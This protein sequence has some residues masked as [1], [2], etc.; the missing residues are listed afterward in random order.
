MVHPSLLQAVIDS[1][2]ELAALL[3]NDPTGSGEA[4]AS[5][6]CSGSSVFFGSVHN[7]KGRVFLNAL[8]CE[9]VQRILLDALR[10]VK[11][12]S[13]V[14]S[15]SEELERMTA[16]VAITRTTGSMWVSAEVIELVKAFHIKGGA[17]AMPS[18]TAFFKTF[19]S[20]HSWYKHIAI[21]VEFGI[22]V[23]TDLKTG[24]PNWQTT[25]LSRLL[26]PNRSFREDFIADECMCTAARKYAWMV[27]GL[28]YDDGDYGFCHTVATGGDAW[29]EWLQSMYPEDV[30]LI[31]SCSTR[32]DKPD[33]RGEHWS[34]FEMDV[35]RAEQNVIKERIKALRAKEYQRL[36]SEFKT[37]ALKVWEVHLT[38]LASTV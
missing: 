32:T 20:A 13:K 10:S 29:F 30:E 33:W 38:M 18:R 14:T 23:M 2:V 31:K 1:T 28:V 21:P 35:P 8:L 34:F 22:T 7:A 26:D 27:N 11:D 5:P 12:S 3:H 6:A 25:Y 4:A 36:L 15:P 9:D 24:L 37:K 19:A 16:F 17:P